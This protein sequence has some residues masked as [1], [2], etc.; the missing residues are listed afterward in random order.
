MAKPCLTSVIF[1][2]SVQ[3]SP[4]PHQAV[5]SFLGRDYISHLRFLSPSPVLG[6]SLFLQSPLTIDSYHA[7][8]CL[9]AHHFFLSFLGVGSFPD[10][11]RPFLLMAR[12][13]FGWLHHR[14]LPDVGKYYN[15]P[16]VLSRASQK[17]PEP[18]REK[19]E[20]Y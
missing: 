4:L 13:G 2:H 10:A 20:G 1:S 6:P 17:E 19:K 14:T 15:T 9:T 18:V 11:S 3:G 7:L 16:S 12:M 8:I 5:K